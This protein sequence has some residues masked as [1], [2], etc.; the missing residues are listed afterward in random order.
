MHSTNPIPLL[1]L[2]LLLLCLIWRLHAVIAFQQQNNFF[3]TS[4]RRTR[5][6]HN[7][8]RAPKNDSFL[9]L[10]LFSNHN[11]HSKQQK[12]AE[13]HESETKNRCG[14][15]QELEGD[16]DDWIMDRREAAFSM[17]GSLWA[18]TGI[19]PTFLVFPNDAAE[20]AYG[21][22]AKMVL[23]N[24]LE[25]MTDRATKQCI[26]ES[27]GNRECLVYAGD[28][29]ER[30][31]QGVENQVLLERVE[32]A[33]IALA[34][35]PPLVEKAKWSQV[36]GILTGPMGELIRTMGQLAELSEN[37]ALAKDKIKV[38]KTDLYAMQ[39]GV[40][41]KDSARVIQSHE[42]ATKDLVAFVKAL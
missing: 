15:C 2:H 41:R 27:L 23:P 11:M 9:F 32:K 40:D 13:D 34:S 5:T 31:Y 3:L 14:P 20:A 25:S 7:T 18:V 21:A 33:S 39:A 19:L 42:A 6:Q 26:V 30:I 4:T 35:I 22:D 10:R 17:L 36:T 28:A 16:N 29:T 1:L 8:S 38:V 12:P 24:P 37:A